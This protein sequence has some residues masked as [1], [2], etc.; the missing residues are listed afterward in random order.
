[1]TTDLGCGDQQYRHGVQPVPLYISHRSCRPDHDELIF[2]PTSCRTFAQGV[3]RRSKPTPRP[4]EPRLLPSG[5]THVAERARQGKASGPALQ[6]THAA[7]VRK[8][9]ET[10]RQP[11]PSRPRAAA[12]LCA[13]RRAAGEATSRASTVGGRRAS[14]LK[15]SREW[16]L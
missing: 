4:R 15:R 14:R 1:M 12:P 6:Q 13:T 11:R 7:V 8:G 5:Q 10:G 3:T 9:A 16:Q 2:F